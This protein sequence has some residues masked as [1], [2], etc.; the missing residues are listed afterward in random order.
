M[1]SGNLNF[2][3]PSGPLQACNGTALPLPCEVCPFWTTTS[4]LRRLE[5]CC[6]ASLMFTMFSECSQKTDEDLLYSRCR[7][8]TICNDLRGETSRDARGIR[9]A[10]TGDLLSCTAWL[11]LQNRN[12][13][14][15][16]CVGPQG[17]TGPLERS[18]SEAGRMTL[19]AFV[20]ITVQTVPTDIGNNCT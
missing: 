1:K 8:S 16:L 18:L 19:R 13:S 2:L 4:C 7:L 11:M 20:K 5:R 6:K 14:R 9:P 3:E 12:A 17:G 10:Q 15:E